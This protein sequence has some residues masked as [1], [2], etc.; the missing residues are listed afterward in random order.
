MR[1]LQIAR[2]MGRDFSLHSLVHIRWIERILEEE[3]AFG[4]CVD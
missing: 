3:M 2:D 1:Q 4:E